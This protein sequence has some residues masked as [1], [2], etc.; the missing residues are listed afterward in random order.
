MGFL[1][2][3]LYLFLFLTDTDGGGT[4]VFFMLLNACWGLLTLSLEALLQFPCR[5]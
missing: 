1:S 2:S 4:S 5:V 3:E